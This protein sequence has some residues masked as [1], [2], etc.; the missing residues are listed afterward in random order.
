MGAPGSSGELGSIPSA[1]LRDMWWEV[2]FAI[3][4]PGQ[5]LASTT[6]GKRRAAGDQHE[7]DNAKTPHICTCTRKQNIETAGSAHV[8]HTKYA[9]QPTAST[10]PIQT[11]SVL[12]RRK[13][14]GHSQ[15]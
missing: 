1:L 4:D 2:I 12:S 5:D 15:C 3:H 9:F 8:M 13:W 10:S 6:I 11:L 14:S 7:E